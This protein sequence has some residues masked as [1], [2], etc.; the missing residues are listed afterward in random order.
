ML[1]GGGSVGGEAADAS[2]AQDP[3]EVGEVNAPSVA[4]EAAAASV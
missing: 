1:N 4:T 2:Q 3:A